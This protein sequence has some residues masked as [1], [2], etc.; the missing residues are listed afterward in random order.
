M[1]KRDGKPVQIGD[2]AL[3]LLVALTER[4]GEILSKR[5]LAEHVWRREWVEDVNLR[6]TIASLRKLL[7]P[8]PEGSDYIVNTVGRGYSFSTAVPAERWPRPLAKQ[9]ASSGTADGPAPGRLPSLLTPVIGRQSEIGHII[10]FLKRQRLVTIVGPGGIGKTTV[11]ISV[12]SHLGDTEGGVCLV[13]F[14]AIQDSSLVPAHVAAALSPERVISEPTSYILGYLSN[15]KRLLVLDNCEHMAE[16]IAG[17]SEA[18]LRSATHVKI[19]ATSREPLRADGEFVYRL[20]GLS[21]PL[22]SAVTDAK[23]ALEF[24]AVQL[25]VERTQASLAQFFLTD[26]LT[27]PVVEICRRLDGIALAI[28][29]A[30][31]R[32]PAFGVNGVAARLDDRFLLLNNGLRTAR[33]RHKTLES[34]FEWSCELLSSDERR[35]FKRLSVFHGPFTIDA[36]TEIAGWPPI[37][38]PDVAA[39]VGDLVG[40]SLVMF[41]GEE[42]TPHYN[43]LETVRVFAQTRLESTGE[44]AEV[45]RRHARRVI[46]QSRE[47]RSPTSREW[48]G[49]SIVAARTVV[50]DLRAAL[51]WAFDV[52]EQV[53]AREL[54]TSGGPLMIHLGLAY[55]LRPW[56]IRA[57]DAETS[58][59]G[60]LALLINLGRSLQMSK[61]DLDSVTQIYEDVRESAERLNDVDSMLHALWGSYLAKW[62]NRQPEL[63]LL[64]ARRF[65]EVANANDRTTDTLVGRF[66]IGSCLHTIGDQRTAETHFRYG[67]ERYDAK[68]CAADTMR[69]PHNHRAFALRFLGCIEWLTGRL[70]AAAE[71]ANRAVLEAGDHLPSLFFVLI[72]CSAVVAIERNDWS[73]AAHYIDVL[74][75]RCGHHAR[76]RVWADALNAILS[77]AVD[78]SRVA[79]SR[80]EDIMMGPDRYQFPAEYIW[81]SVHFIKAYMAF[82]MTE[83]ASV[84]ANN[85]VGHYRQ[86]GEYWLMP[87]LLRLKGMLDV[88]NDLDLAEES[89]KQARELA[90]SQRAIT[91]ELDI[92][93]SYASNIRSPMSKRFAAELLDN[94]PEGVGPPG[95]VAALRCLSQ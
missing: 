19:I 63:A 23:R 60:R 74:Y 72:N 30:A 36:A 3:D 45:A 77:I 44:C 58:A 79:L 24:S 66:L 7:G 41:T 12:A 10:G 8:A 95:S 14:A 25:F 51:R 67:L 53:L 71:T 49:S 70:D 80:L 17:I 64:A 87:E 55:E 40:K 52:G 68:A 61:C 56:I 31:S 62:R 9:D 86:R 94:L 93:T 37:A 21:Y 5:E 92:A 50:D 34:V 85:S 69:Y 59:E 65:H 6:V 73:A 54:V 43:M 1:L 28:R 4:P 18:I 20:D 90:R 26:A 32:V 82:D 27:A 46:T 47:F 42:R 33:P 16:A 2:K 84:Y 39:I 35:V 76:W 38:A 81:F 78:R 91:L 48:E 88:E 89:F 83:Q 57:L 15:K 29:L 11:A 75:R 22:E 13:D